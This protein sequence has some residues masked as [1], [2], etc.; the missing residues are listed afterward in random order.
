[1]SLFQSLFRSSKSKSTQ[2]TRRTWRRRHRS[3]ATATSPDGEDKP[4]LSTEDA[5]TDQPVPDGETGT[6][7]SSEE[8]TRD[9]QE[10]ASA[11]APESTPE[12]STRQKQQPSVESVRSSQ[13]SK[14]KAEVQHGSKRL[15]KLVARLRGDR[16]HDEGSSLSLVEAIQ[17]T[18]PEES[19]SMSTQVNADSAE[20]DIPTPLDNSVKDPANSSDAETE[21]DTIKDTKENVPSRAPSAIAHKDNQQRN[22]SA[23]TA[24]SKESKI[25]G[26]TVSRHPS[27][28]VQDPLESFFGTEWLKFDQGATHQ[29]EAS[30]PF[31]DGKM[32]EAPSIMRGPSRRSKQSSM[33][34]SSASMQPPGQNQTDTLASSR[35]ASRVGSA[36]SHP[37]RKTVLS[38]L[39]PSKATVAFNTLASRIAVPLSIPVNDLEVA[40]GK[41][42]TRL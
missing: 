3:K 42:S 40:G 8:K 27:Q 35:Q 16:S 6:A 25:T 29:P 33:R 41:L 24:C 15:K 13:D 31:S 23:Q 18:E 28:R 21:N 11:R 37:S 14:E 7:R 34:K 1:M 20:N 26:A 4:V 39:D 12:V 22:V 32:A 5:K 38:C 36:S 30:D 17:P 10:A 9:D 19:T 2:Q